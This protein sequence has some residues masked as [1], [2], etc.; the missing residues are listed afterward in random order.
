MTIYSLTKPSA[1][2]LLAVSSL[3][4]CHRGGW[5]CH[6]SVP[7]EVDAEEGMRIFGLGSRVFLQFRDKENVQ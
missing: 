7:V 4:Q 3:G 6:D 1:L 2:H 5:R